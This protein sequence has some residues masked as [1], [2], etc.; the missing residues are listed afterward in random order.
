MELESKAA[1]LAEVLEEILDDEEKIADINL[2]SRPLR[3]ARQKRR[4]RNR[5]RREQNVGRGVTGYVLPALKF[6]CLF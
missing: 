2:S 4:D 6:C 5:L 1:T 3:E